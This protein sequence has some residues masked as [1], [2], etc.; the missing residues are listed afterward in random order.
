MLKDLV[1]NCRSYRRFYENVK[2]SDAGPG[3]DD[4]FHG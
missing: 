4:R 1:Y 3:Q 2:I